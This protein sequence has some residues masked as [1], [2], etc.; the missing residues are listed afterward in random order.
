M[1]SHLPPLNIRVYALRI[2]DHKIMIVEEEYLGKTIIK[3]PG[4]GLEY[5]E[6]TINCLKRELMEELEVEVD[7]ITHYYTTDFFQKSAWDDRQI[8]S[9]YYLVDFT[10][11]APFAIRNEVGHFYL[12]TYTELISQDLLP[13]DRIVVKKLHKDGLI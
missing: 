2:I 6:G 4:G 8:I 3:F 7:T 1:Y 11:N 10:M 12:T 9:I 5:G 13:I